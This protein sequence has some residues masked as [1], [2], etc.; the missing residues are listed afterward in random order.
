LIDEAET[1]T[2]SPDR[3]CLPSRTAQQRSAV[4]AKGCIHEKPDGKL[5]RA[6]PMRDVAYCFFHNPETE[7]QAAESRRLGGLRRKREKA[8]AGAYDFAGLDSIESIRRVLEIALLD[9][10]S[11]ENSLARSRTLITGGMAAMKLLEVG[12][13][14]TRIEILEAASRQRP[15]LP[16]GLDGALLDKP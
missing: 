13:L 2:R 7:E 5:C 12:E 3:G 9:A 16:S 8:V 6:T 1:P 15:T 4:V 14:Q 11:L 10:L